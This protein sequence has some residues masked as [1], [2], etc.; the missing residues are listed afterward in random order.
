[1]NAPASDDVLIVTAPQDSSPA[2]FSNDIAVTPKS[3]SS[4]ISLPN[5]F[6]SENA[7][8]AFL[9]SHVK[10]KAPFARIEANNC[11]I[12]DRQSVTYVVASKMIDVWGHYPKKENML[13]VSSLLSNITG[14]PS[15]VF[16]EPK[17]WRGGLARSV[18]NAR[19]LLMASEKRW[20][21]GE[22]SKSKSDKSPN[23]PL[24]VTSSQS[25]CAVSASTSVPDVTSFTGCCRQIED[26]DCCHG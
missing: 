23:A 18:E 21:W 20:T 13:A 14:L 25:S 1:M 17:S 2:E 4:Q 19:R 5:C 26:C 15:V 10:S 3:G 22:N 11:S 12:G 24:S 16:F 7:L 6:A 8:K 9:S